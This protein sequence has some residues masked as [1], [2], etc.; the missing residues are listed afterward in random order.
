[1]KVVSIDGMMCGHCQAH[2]EKALNDINGVKA[3]VDLEKKCA[4]I[5]LTSNVDDS[6]LIKAVEEAGYNVKGIQ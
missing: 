6:V 2:V 3:T 1:M 5:D 4:Y